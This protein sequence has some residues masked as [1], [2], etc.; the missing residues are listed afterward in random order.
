L[1]KVD[2]AAVLLY[3]QTNEMLCY[4]SVFGFSP[5][6]MVGRCFKASFGAADRP[7][8]DPGNGERNMECEDLE[9][10]EAVFERGKF[11]SAFC[12][13]LIA[14]NEVLGVLEIYH[15][16]PLDPD[17]DWL[18]VLHTI[19]NQTTIAIENTS[20]FEDL[21][22]SN[23]ELTQAYDRTLEGWAHALELRDKE[24]E[25]HCRRVTEMTLSLAREMGITSEEE[26]LQIRRGTLLHDIGKMGI[27]DSI[28]LKPGP[29]TEE[30][31]EIMRQHPVYAYELLSPIPYL[32][33]ALDIPYFHHER[34]DGSGYPHGLKEDLIPLPARMFAVV[35]VWEA[36]SSD[37]PYR[38]AWPEKKVAA[39]LREN[40]GA[41]F[42][43]QIV[44]AFLY[45]LER[46]KTAEQ[47]TKT[48]Q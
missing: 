14:K 28:L 42:D 37:R 45:M 40:A 12:L 29:L 16:Q 33:P 44:K 25:G 11:A 41:H 1:L 47:E 19:T 17:D 48:T 6:T 9:R 46:E 31:W 15:R 38:D 4:V 20:L 2:G 23:E 30:E 13:P 8:I 18:S 39:Y 21:T 3:E 35:D 10:L 36:L 26:L 34:W 24:T 32:L 22:Y 7:E 27:P 5:D 43:P